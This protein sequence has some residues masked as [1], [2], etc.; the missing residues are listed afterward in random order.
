MLS[1]QVQRISRHHNLV[2]S[3]TYNLRIILNSTLNKHYSQCA[4]L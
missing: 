4:N 3:D 2:M 1:D